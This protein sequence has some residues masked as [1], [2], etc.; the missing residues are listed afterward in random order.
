MILM[1]NKMILLSYMETLIFNSLKLISIFEVNLLQTNLL[2]ESY[3][4]LKNIPLLPGNL[5]FER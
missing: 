2:L 4:L 5:L 1:M 3:L